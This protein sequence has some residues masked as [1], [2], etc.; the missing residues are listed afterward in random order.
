MTAYEDAKNPNDT[1][2]CGSTDCEFEDLG[3]FAY[4][5]IERT[6][7]SCGLVAQYVDIYR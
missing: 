3:G 1:C 5:V 6:C 4:P 7:K 2:D